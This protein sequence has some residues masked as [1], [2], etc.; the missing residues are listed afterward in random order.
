MTDAEKRVYLEI[1]MERVHNA[2][3]ELQL[4]C[5]QFKAAIDLASEPEPELIEDGR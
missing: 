1:S 3:R 2:Q 5:A 4:A